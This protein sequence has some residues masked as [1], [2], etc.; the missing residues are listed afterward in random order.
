MIFTEGPHQLP[1]ITFSKIGT[2]CTLL[3]NKNNGYIVD[4]LTYGNNQVVNELKL[5]KESI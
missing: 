2:F 4:M 5:A 1:K 3:S